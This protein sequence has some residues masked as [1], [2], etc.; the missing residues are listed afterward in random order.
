MLGLF[1]VFAYNV[2]PSLTVISKA[3]WFSSM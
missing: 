3:Y 2:Q 1:T